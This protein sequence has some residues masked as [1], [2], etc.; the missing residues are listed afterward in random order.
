MN[1]LDYRS[2]SR[3]T[4]CSR[5]F[6]ATGKAENDSFNRKLLKKNQSGHWIVAGGR[7]RAGDAL[8]LILPSTST[9]SGYPRELYVGVVSGV[10]NDGANSTLFTVRKFFLLQPVRSQVKRFLMGKVPPMGNT[11]QDIWTVSTELATNQATFVSAVHKAGEDSTSRRQLRLRSAS[12]LPARIAITTEIFVRNPDVVAEVLYLAK[13]IC[14]RCNQQA[15]FL[16]GSDQSPYLEVHHQI[17]L[18]HGGEDTVENAIAL[19]PNCHREMHYGHGATR[20]FHREN[21]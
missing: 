8:F 9:K 4:S 14:G 21:I 3:L 5:A 11:V 10:E 7:V 18:A 2:D 12:R 17:L 20:L 15:P 16:R 19:C 6:L 13:N 1:I